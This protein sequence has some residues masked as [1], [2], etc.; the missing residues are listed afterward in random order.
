MIPEFIKKLTDNGYVLGPQGY[1]H[2]SRL[3]PVEAAQP[4]SDQRGQIEGRGVVRRQKGGPKDRPRT[5]HKSSGNSR[6]GTARLVVTIVQLR[7][8]LLDDHDNLRASLKA[9]VDGI[10]EIV[11]I[12]D[13]DPRVVWEYGQMVT[14]GEEGVLVRVG[15]ETTL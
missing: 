4:Q 9:F 3:R 2:K 6:G 5:R 12:K 14:S 11:G 15:L 1:T 8:R 7:R 13:N 10:A